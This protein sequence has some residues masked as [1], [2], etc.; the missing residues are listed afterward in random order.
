MKMTDSDLKSGHILAILLITAAVVAGQIFL[1]NRLK[2]QENAA[3]TAREN[4]SATASVLEA[5][6][7]A[8]MR[9]K[10]TVKI[11]ESELPSPVESQSRL[12]TALINAFSARGLDGVNVEKA[13]E[14]GKVISFRASGALPYASLLNVLSSFRQSPYLI[15]LTEL[16]LDGEK[17]NI[18][19]FAFSVSAM[20]ENA[21]EPADK[22]DNGKKAGGKKK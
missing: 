1:M 5:R 12:Y 16:S 14:S 15:K 18:V 7:E 10:S 21:E 3:A 13:S 4:A 11:D 22:A 2:I 9:Y 17:N 20:T 19:K 8:L 6:S